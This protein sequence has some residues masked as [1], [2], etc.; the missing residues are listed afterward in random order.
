MLVEEMR[1][2]TL[3]SV[4]IDGDKSMRNSIKRVLTN[5][6]HM[7]CAY[8]TYYTIL[9]LILAKLSLFLSSNIVYSEIVILMSF[10]RSGNI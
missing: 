4:I 10:S 7:L 3:K 8:D 6:D 5:F 2:K 9:L 1:G